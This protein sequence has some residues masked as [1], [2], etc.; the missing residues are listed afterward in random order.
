MDYEKLTEEIRYYCE[1]HLSDKRYKHSVRVAEMCSEIAEL[2][3]YSKEKAYLTGIAHDICKEIPKDEMVR[4]AENSKWSVSDYERE[5]PGLLHGKAGAVLLNE[6]FGIEDDEILCAVA[7]HVS[8]TMELPPLGMIIFIADK[9][10]RGRSQV[11]EK[12]IE[13]LYSKPI[14][15]MFSFAVETSVRYLLN[16]GYVIYEETYKMMEELGI[17]L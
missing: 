12:Y 5:N 10:E 13:D 17:K 16:K 14:R 8:G 1:M 3:G 4:I 2:C 6:K 9:N 7:N 15:E 11:T